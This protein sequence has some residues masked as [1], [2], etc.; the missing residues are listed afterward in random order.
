MDP[1]PQQLVASGD[2]QVLTSDEPIPSYFI[3][4]IHVKVLVEVCPR[5]ELGAAANTIALYDLRR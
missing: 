3:A 4:V 1:I 5:S 2:N